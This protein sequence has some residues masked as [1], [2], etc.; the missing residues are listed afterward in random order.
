[1][2]AAQVEIPEDGFVLLLFLFLNAFLSYGWMDDENYQKV[3]LE[4]GMVLS[5]PFSDDSGAR[6]LYEITRIWNWRG[7]DSSVSPIIASSY[8]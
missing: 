4:N 1:M 5:P 2:I 3:T 8:L 6:R 7:Y